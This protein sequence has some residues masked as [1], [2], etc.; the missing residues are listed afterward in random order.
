MNGA[1]LHKQ[2]EEAREKGDFLNSIKLCDEA[3]LAYAKESNIVKLAEVQVSRA[4]AFRH[5]GEQNDDKNFLILAKYAA[6]S[7]VKIIENSGSDNGKTLPL[8]TLGKV[9]ESLEKFDKA[10]EEIKDAIESADSSTS[11]EQLAE[12]KTRLDA[13]T[14]RL[15]DNSGLESFNAD[16]SDLENGEFSDDYVKNVW[17]S[18]AYLHM[19]KALISKDEKDKAKE[20]LEK[21]RTIID[22]DARLTL[23]A[24]QLAEIEKTLS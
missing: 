10:S 9:Y 17:V 7:G 14:Y 5:L 13:I 19:A 16:V 23:R 22:S 6:K 2:A 21:A 18:G 12:M 4:L 3:T 11:K 15:G 1:D 20:L 24:N 8:Q